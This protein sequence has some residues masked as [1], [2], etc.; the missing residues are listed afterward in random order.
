MEPNPY[1][2]AHRKALRMA[3]A[4]TCVETGF[5]SISESA[6][7]TITEMA[8]SYI[9]ELA[10]SSRG[11]AELAGRT[12]PMV[13]DISLALVEMGCDVTSLPGFLRQRRHKLNTI[14]SPG[15]VHEP[16]KPR[17]LQVGDKRNLPV[18]VP[19]YYPPFPDSHCYIRTPTFKPPVNEY[20]MVR[21]KNASQKRDVE[22]ALT[23]FIAKTSS[24]ISLF[25]IP[26]SQQEDPDKDSAP[27][28]RTSENQAEA[29]A[30]TVTSGANSVSSSLVFNSFPL[31]NNLPVDRP[32]L[33]ALLTEDRDSS[34][35]DVDHL[36]KKDVAAAA[37]AA[38]VA[39]DSKMEED[40]NDVDNPY[41][42]NVKMPKIE[43]KKR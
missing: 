35:A 37:A 14:S 32:Y 5:S 7:E 23:K 20:Q 27:P 40:D 30:E 34:D 9:H 41:V 21:E 43:K 2:S 13:T 29:A 11:L 16:N 24:T 31:I 39:K 6:L 42:R 17:T 38:A 3:I 8:I 28:N 10:K 15:V 33:T 4:S 18:H 25:A 22:R 26:G 12:Q 36:V 1:I 19:E